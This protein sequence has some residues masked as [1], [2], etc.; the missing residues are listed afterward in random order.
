MTLEERYNLFCTTPSSIN[1]YL[2]LLRQYAEQCESVVEFGVDIGQS[3]TAFLMAK[4]V[5][6]ISVDVT[7]TPEL[8]ALRDSAAKTWTKLNGGYTGF[9]AYVGHTHW[10]FLQASSLDV[11][12]IPSDL[13]LIDSSH[14]YAQTKAELERHARKIR[15]WIFLHDTVAYG[16]VGEA[17]L[18]G[19]LPA[20]REFLQSHPQWSIGSDLKHNNG[21]M[22]LTRIKDE[23]D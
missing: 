9:C 6:F 13:L 17:N 10:D 23:E 22:I 3:T 20:I 5:H 16:E 14:H 2:P 8:T 15:K 18:V 19:I 4:P 1:E 7:Q 11:S 21:M 12:I